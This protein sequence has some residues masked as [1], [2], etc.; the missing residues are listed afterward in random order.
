[1]GAAVYVIK[2]VFIGEVDDTIHR[3]G[4]VSPTNYREN[5]LTDKS[6]FEFKQTPQT[7]RQVLLP[8]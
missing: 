4:G 1:M 2:L 6:K 3:R 7:A 8:N 5:H